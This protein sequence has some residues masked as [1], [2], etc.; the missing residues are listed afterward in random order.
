MKTNKMKKANKK[1]KGT[2]HKN[3]SATKLSVLDQDECSMN[4]Y[5]YQQT[6]RPSQRT[7]SWL[8][9]MEQ[10]INISE[11]QGEQRQHDSNQRN[12][13]ESSLL[14]SGQFDHS[15]CKRLIGDEQK[16]TEG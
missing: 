14:G 7:V 4:T 8:P 10:G 3:V 11:E 1:S 5:V 12:A 13:K 9:L 6:L 2:K 16:E 15:Y